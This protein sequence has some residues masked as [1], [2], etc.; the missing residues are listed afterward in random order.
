MPDEEIEQVGAGLAANSPAGVEVNWQDRALP[1]LK[2]CPETLMVPS[3][4]PYPGGALL[5]D[6]VTVGTAKLAVS[7]VG[8]FMVT[9][10]GLL[11]PV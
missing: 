2:P 8:E 9:L 11:V 5:G 3:E 1:G 4:A 6:K 10:A 7:V